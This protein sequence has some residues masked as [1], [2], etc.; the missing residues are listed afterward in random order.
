M[1]P[2]MYTSGNGHRY[3]HVHVYGAMVA[4]MLDMNSCLFIMSRK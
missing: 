3:I 4:C 2:R 1:V